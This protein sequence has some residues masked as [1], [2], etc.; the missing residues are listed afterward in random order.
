MLYSILLVAQVIISIALVVFVLLQ[1]G[2]GADAGAAFGSGASATVFGSQGSANFL[3]R[4]T[5]ILATLFFLN[6]MA[7]TYLVSHR[8][9]PKSVVDEV[10]VEQPAAQQE[11]TEA[12]APAVAPPAD[13]PADVPA[14]VPPPAT[15]AQPA[16]QAADVPAPADAGAKPAGK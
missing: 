4:T 8:E 1:H 12:P 16:D 7:M 10:S 15:G 6:S 11:A 14:D 3:T 5:A 13:L 2:K 9:G